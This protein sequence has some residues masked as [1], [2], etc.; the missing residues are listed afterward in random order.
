MAGEELTWLEESSVSER[1]LFV[2]GK[3]AREMMVFFSRGNF[4][5]FSPK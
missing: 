5:F 1:K 2:Q 3:S 4:V